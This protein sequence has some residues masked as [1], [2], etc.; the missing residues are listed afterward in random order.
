MLTNSGGQDST[1]LLL[2]ISVLQNQYKYYLFNIYCNHLWQRSSLQLMIQLSRINFIHNNNFLIISPLLNLINENLSRNWRYNTL[3]RLAC[4]SSFEYTLVAHTNSDQIESYFLNIFRGS[5]PVGLT[6]FKTEQINFYIKFI[7]FTDKKISFSNMIF[8][9]KIRFVNKYNIKL[10]FI[11]SLIWRPLV[12]FNRFEIQKLYKV[13]TLPI[14]TDKT[15]YNLHYR[16]NRIRFEL[17]PY[18]RFYFNSKVDIAILRCIENIVSESKFFKKI[19]QKAFKTSYIL[20]SQK[21][22]IIHDY[23]KLYQYPS[24]IKKNIIIDSLTKLNIKVSNSSYIQFILKCICLMKQYPKYNT[25]HVFFLSN[26]LLICFYGNY[27]YI[28]RL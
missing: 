9:I 20:G 6:T 22:I 28:C 23:S 11:W 13:L 16:R 19:T 21:Q 4:F 7:G 26:I 3:S 15:N 27:V 17:L 10:K 5:G 25:P 2:L 14:W 24:N 1:V 8:K 12:V 18:L